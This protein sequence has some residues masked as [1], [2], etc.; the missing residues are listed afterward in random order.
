MRTLNRAPLRPD[1]TTGRPLPPTAFTSFGMAAPT[2]SH[3]IEYPCSAA[4]CRGYV[5]GWTT[6]LD[7]MRSEHL[8]F[9]KHIVDGVSGRRW[10]RGEVTAEGYL[11]FVFPPGQPCFRNSHHTRNHDV[12]ELYVVRGGDFRTPHRQRELHRMGFDNWLEA[13]D[14]N[15]TALVK[16]HEA[17]RE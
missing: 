17:M 1:P 16:G 15:Q 7:P 3:L 2:R 9:I 13:F 6:I 10:S 11:T 8:P 5:H 4:Q 14:R 12:P